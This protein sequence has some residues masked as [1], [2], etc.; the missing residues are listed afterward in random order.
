MVIRTHRYASSIILIH[1]QGAYKI[2]HG[3]LDDVAGIAELLKVSY[4]SQELQI[5]V[6]VPGALLQKTTLGHSMLAFL[7]LLL[8]KFIVYNFNDTDASLQGIQLAAVLQL[9]DSSLVYDC[10]LLILGGVLPLLNLH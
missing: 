2:L 3:L 6:L 7:R 5:N 4:L 9:E 10:K 8:V 1:Y